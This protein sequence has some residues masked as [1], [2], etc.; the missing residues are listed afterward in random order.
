M[1]REQ[2]GVGVQSGQRGQRGSKG[3]EET[4]EGGKEEKNRA[5]AAAFMERTPLCSL[6]GNISGAEGQS[7]ILSTVHTVLF[8][9]FSHTSP[10]REN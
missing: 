3:E 4:R 6:A 5:E 8:P 9:R 2:E 7:R 1:D 10:L